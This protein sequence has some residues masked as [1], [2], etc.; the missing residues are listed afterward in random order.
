M[1]I[2]LDSHVCCLGAKTG[3]GWYASHLMQKL[4]RIDVKNSYELHLFDFCH[5]NQRKHKLEKLLGFFPPT[6][7]RVNPWLPYGVY[8]RLPFLFEK[9]SYNSIM[10]SKADIYHFFNFII[11]KKIRGKTITTVY[12]MV[13]K[14]Y[15]ETMSNVNRRIHARELARS[16]QH[17][18]LILT[19]SQNSQRQIAEFMHV[20]EE[21][22]H[23]AYPAVDRS[24]FYP[25]QNRQYLQE[26]YQI[27]QDYFLYLGTLEPRKNIPRLVQAFH[28][29]SQKQ[30]DVI[31]V[32]AGQKGW[33]YEE[34]FKTIQYLKLENKVRFLG[35]V[36][37]ED[38]RVLYSGAR[39]FLFP[40]LYEGFG[41][42][43]LE[44]MA[45]G[46]PVVVSNTS[47]LPEVVGAAGL[48]V[49]PLDVENMAEAMVRIT[50]NDTLREN[51][52]RAGLLQAQKFS[53]ENAAK[54]VLKMY[55]ILD[56]SK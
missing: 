48:Y 12:D 19:I 45:C 39:A 17:A 24:Q 49:N 35:Y 44:A 18:D 9:I 25:E 14:L 15:P 2:A 51:N 23:I 5:R 40:S 41:M 28:V 1:Q 7:A 42:P 3:V 13:Y 4:L 21:K 31:L 55:E 43:P 29:V 6:Q 20:P 37:D 52:I 34:I 54:V 27:Q 38:K 16:C 50:E 32:L 36:P 11:P 56:K 53:W 46:T 33:Q 10:H 8:M 30:K 26:K 47:S 22:I